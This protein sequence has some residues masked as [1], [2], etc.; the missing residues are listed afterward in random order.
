M[1]EDSKERLLVGTK[2]GLYLYSKELENFSHIELTSQNKL[3]VSVN[4]II[5]DP[6]GNI[7]LATDGF[8]LYILNP[9][10]TIKKIYKTDKNNPNSIPTNYIWSI[11]K[12]YN[13]G[14]WLGTVKDGLVFFDT[15]NEVFSKISKGEDIKIT[16]PTI[17]T[18][19]CDAENNIWI[20]TLSE[21]LYRYNLKSGKVSNY[22]HG[23]ALT[24]K[25]IIDYSDKELIMGSDKG[26]IVFD[27]DKETYRL[28]NQESYFDNLTDKSIFSIAKDKEG[29]FWIGTYFGG[30]NYYSPV[31]NK[32]NFYPGYSSSS[33]Y[34]DFISERDIIKDFAEDDDGKI[35]IA[36]NNSGYSSFDPKTKQIKT[37]PHTRSFQNI[38][39]LLFAYNKLYFS[40]FE[41]GIYTLNP[42]DGSVNILSGDA[43]AH[44]N[45]TEMCQTSNGKIFFS[46]EDGVSY[47]NS[48]SDQ[49][50]RIKELNQ[51]PVKWI[52][53][54]YKGALWFATSYQGLIRLS[55][56]GE[57][58]RFLRKSKNNPQ[59]PINNINCVYQDSKFRLWIG[60]EGEGL[61][62]YNNKENS[63]EQLYCFFTKNTSQVPFKNKE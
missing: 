49:P 11:T 19:H 6:D 24:I 1:K 36:S 33:G 54:D 50:K 46:M 12:D 42:K 57:W 35:W 55:S 27:K 61:F 8:G 53:E 18:L 13:G 34:S 5:E 60:T 29:S 2:G 56:E 62:L 40:V 3:E 28:L 31:V 38:Q 17:F 23:E 48:E 37:F 21:G 10:L 4:A 59:L 44:T 41:K 22:M 25:S 63:F 39:S 20:G 9:D 32:I 26:L 14:T 47:I 43:F 51:I 15:K 7:W 30:I 58:T 45:V 16:D 52:E